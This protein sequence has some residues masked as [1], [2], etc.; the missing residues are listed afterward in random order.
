MNY[1][2]YLSTQNEE[3]KQTIESVIEN[4]NDKLRY[5]SSSKFQGH[6]NNFVNAEEAY[7]MLAEI[8][9]QLFLSGI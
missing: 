7:K 2:N 8:K 1:I 4:L 3:F 9:H 5:L 6:D